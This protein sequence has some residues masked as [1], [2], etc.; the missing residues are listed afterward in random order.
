MSGP[1]TP[2][3]VPSEA[4]RAE[5]R[6]RLVQVVRTKGYE[7]RDEPFELSSGKLSHDF[8]D[9]KRALAAGADLE[10]ACRYFVALA[11][12]AG[13][14]FEAVGGLTMGA[15]QFAHGVAI[16]AGCD[17]FVVRKAPKGRGTNKV[18]EGA[19]IT[20]RRVVVCEDAVSTGGSILKA[21]E[22]AEAH[23]AT[24]VGAF[25]LVDRGDAFTAVMRDRGIWY[26]PIMT[27]HD[28]GIEPIS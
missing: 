13:V 14:A 20:G 5:W 8:V 23:G 4:D 19:D 1:V 28:L 3:T 22:A 9:G 11:A 27:Y 16:V 18:L 12:E 7:Y 2:P 6:E 10:L 26:R 21:I 24:V 15:D 25:T 17:W